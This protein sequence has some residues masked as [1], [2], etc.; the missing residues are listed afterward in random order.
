MKL[1]NGNSFCSAV[2]QPAVSRA[3]S[4]HRHVRSWRQRIRNP[5][6]SR[7]E[8]CATTLLLVLTVFGRTSSALTLDA[9]LQATLEKNPAIQEAKL[10][11]EQAAGQRLILRS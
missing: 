8:V 5:R 2:F 10:N 7:L 4:R 1:E 11:L 3:S 9:A 6:H